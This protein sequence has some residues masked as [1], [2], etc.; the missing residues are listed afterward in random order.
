ML[1]VRF[2]PPQFA[3]G[4]MFQ[5]S[6]F[7]RCQD[8][9]ERYIACDGFPRSERNPDEQSDILDLCRSPHI[10]AH[11]GYWLLAEFYRRR[12]GLSQ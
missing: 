12:R 6:H 11:A 7:A 3:F 5:Q 9:H 4:Q 2:F 1:I 10:A 8:R